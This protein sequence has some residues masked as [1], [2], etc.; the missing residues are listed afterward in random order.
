MNNSADVIVIGAGIVGLSTAYYLAK[1]GKSVIILE[2]TDGN[3]SCSYGNAG[4]IAPSHIIPLASPGIISKGLRWMLN[5]ESPFYIKPRLNMGLAKWGINFVKSA[6]HEH[7][8]RSK[9]LLA[10]ICLF[11]QDLHN[12]FAKEENIKVKKT[13][14]IMQ[15]LTESTLNHEKEL[16][17]MTMDFGMDA[18]I[19]E[20]EELDQLDPKLKH[21]GVGAVHFTEDTFM[22]PK[23]FMENMKRALLELGVTTYTNQE[24]ID[25]DISGRKISSVRTTEAEY[26]GNEVVLATGAFTP[27]L[28]KMVGN[29]LLIE[30]GKGYSVDYYNEDLV[31]D[32]SYILVEARVAITPLE[33]F[34]RVAGTMELAG[35]NDNINHRRV[36]GYLKNVKD[37]LPD[38]NYEDMK[39]LPVWSGFRPCSPD[40]LPYIGRDIKYDNLIVAAGHA[41]IGF[42]LGP[43]TGKLVTEIIKGQELTINIDKLA[44]NRY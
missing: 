18:A 33:K 27:Q 7:V 5:P 28:A 16:A 40:G 39:D 19:L 20:I 22:D 8:D 13:G 32:L 34:V 42:T 29:R 21:K 31:S 38:F 10:D 37:Y 36:A 3:D 23:D 12:E 9:Q 30:A 41:M 6:T 35:L 15:C 1:E 25:F 24:V 2:K 14:V 17:K 44:V 11:S 26:L 4:Y 43:A